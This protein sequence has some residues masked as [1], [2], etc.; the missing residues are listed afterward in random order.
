MSLNI[1]VMGPQGSGKG[2]QSALLS[3]K[4]GIPAISTGDILRE[5]IRLKTDVGI[6]AEKYISNGMLVPSRLISTLLKNRLLESDASKG[7]ILDG[8]PRSFYQII[9]L[10]G[11]LHNLK[12]QINVVIEITG[13]E[14][15]LID[16]ML[17]RA[18]IEGRDDDRPEII[19]RRLEVYYK[20][21]LPVADEYNRRKQ[22]VSVNGIGDIQD[23]A[24]EID[25]IV[26]KAIEKKS[27]NL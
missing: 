13:P 6:L 17:K 1:I 10:D 2:T 7:F 5:N 23:I 9:L 27:N 15:E 19:K 24:R 21:T 3:K 14:D 11:I 12:K 18:I 22:L 4:Y 20:E 8:Y 16:R 26:G 25:S